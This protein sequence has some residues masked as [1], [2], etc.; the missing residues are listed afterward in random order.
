MT[1]AE[2]LEHVERYTEALLTNEA[3]TPLHTVGVDLHNILT[4]V[5]DGLAS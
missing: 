1:A 2:V 4:E 3:G 5:P